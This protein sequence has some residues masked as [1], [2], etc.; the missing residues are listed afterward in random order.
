MP[1]RTPDDAQ[2]QTPALF[3]EGGEPTPESRARSRPAERAAELRHLLDYHAY[4]YYAL[5][6]PDQDAQTSTPGR[7]LARHKEAH[8]P[9]GDA[10]S[11]HSQRWGLRLQPVRRGAPRRA[12]TPSTT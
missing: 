11:Y 4:R 8:D 12:C 3:D 1:S 10:D 6:D 7:E 9:T 5:D 2:S